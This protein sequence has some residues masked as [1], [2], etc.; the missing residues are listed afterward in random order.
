M[1][2]HFHADGSAVP[3]TAQYLPRP[4]VDILLHGALAQ[5][6]TTVIAGPGYG[7]T[8]AVL[9]ALEGLQCKFAWM[10]VSEMDNNVAIVW[11]HLVSTMATHHSDLA[12][13]LNAMGFPDSAAAMYQLLQLLQRTLPK[14]RRFVLVL[15]DFHMIQDEAILLFF[16]KLITAALP[17][18]SFV[19]I[20]REKPR[21]P[22]AGMLARGRLARVTEEDLRFTPDEM[23]A[24]YQMQGIALDAA[25]RSKLYIYTEGWI[26]AIYLIGLSLKRRSIHGH[27][28][29]L[30]AKPDIFALIEEEVFCGAS[31]ALRQYLMTVALLD[32]APMGLLQELAKDAPGVLEEMSGMR[33]LIRYDA[34]LDRLRMHR[35]YREFLLEKSADLPGEVLSHIHLTAA[36][37]YRLHGWPDEAIHHY[38][39]CGHY[40]EIF[41][42]IST[43]RGHV[44]RE[45]AAAYIALIDSAPAA[46]VAST[47]LIRVVKAKFLFNNNHIQE[48]HDELSRIQAEYEA[49]PA[50][51]E[52][53]AI[54][55]EAYIL[56]AL[57]SMYRQ[58]MDFVPFF[59]RAAECL[60]DGSAL[61]D[62]HFN[63]AEGINMIGVKN[64]VQ[65]ELMRCQAA[66]FAAAPYADTAMNGCG[67]GMAHLFAT[68][69][70]FFT[71]DM[72]SA[73]RYAYET[74]YHAQEKQ[75]CG[76]QHMANFYLLR[77]HVCKGDYTKAIHLLR[78]MQ[79]EIE[80]LQDTGCST[81]YDIA[82]GWFNVK[83]GR[84]DEVASW[85]LHQE[86]TQRVLAPVFLGREHLVR[87]DYLLATGR[88][89]EHLGY[90]QQMDVHY[91]RRGILYGQIHNRI[92]Q[93]IIHHYL[94]H[95]AESM[96][97]LEAAWAL[98]HENNLV[99]LFIEYGSKMRT[100]VQAALQDTT[101][102]IPQAWLKSI[103]TKSSTYAKRLAQIIKAIDAENQRGRP[104]QINLSKREL[105]VLTCLCQGLT[106]EEIA[107]S[108]GLSAN[109]V[110]SVLQSIYNK[111]GA[112]NSLDAVR[113]AT[114]MGLV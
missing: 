104:G 99:T 7:K 69:A 52:N 13:R 12:M 41:E 82:E 50:T 27:D 74:I 15:D 78:Q 34:Q 65:G 45:T 110:R 108:C 10:Q 93:S 32:I 72:Q 3:D 62:R 44:P 29:M 61:I 16:E 83:T 43:P 112:I 33:M 88:D 94:G 95:H 100:V 47:P 63:I 30:A 66:M 59:A 91:A 35:L 79:A 92:A 39:K 22:L 114:V 49:L 46:A 55:G 40:T 90:L 48:A 73:E 31:D 23:A 87:S 84:H 19:L 21:L 105:E 76:I 60:P 20:G 68:D 51:R 57:I 38:V 56:R 85:I 28:P 36:H 107:D 102:T 113:I 75:Q 80:C 71:G 101:C 64:P 103:H 111:L 70:A 17:Y 26:F 54:L 109:T 2:S 25:T 18:L 9:S 58:T 89:L 67:H 42:I 6:L 53:R 98:S 5:P 81:I 106:R 24:Y 37:W 14:D 8:H 97:A 4:R 11:R 86:E 1:P 77:I 96:A